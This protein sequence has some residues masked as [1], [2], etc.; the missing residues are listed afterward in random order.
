MKQNDFKMIGRDE[1]N[2]VKPKFPYIKIFPQRIIIHHSAT[3][4][5]RTRTSKF[6]KGHKTVFY[7][8]KKHIKKLG[9][10]DIK[11]H[12]IIAPDGTI[13][14]GR[15]IGTAGCHC[16][17]YD[18][19]TLAIL[20]MGNFNI[21]TVPNEQLRSLLMTLKYIK[22]IY[23]HMDI[24]KCVKNHRDYEHTLCPGHHLSNLINV[25]KTRTWNI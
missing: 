16:R 6:Y 4:S 23:K 13:Y 2:A 5:S 25:I 20:F 9:L 17:S 22:S 21:E 11:Y 18:N 3:D 24:P 1:W 15:P 19:T 14:E 7:M 8:Q 10:N 12:F